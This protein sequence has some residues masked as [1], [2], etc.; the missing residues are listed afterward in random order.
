MHSG[1]GGG[2]GTEHA[3]TAESGERD[4]AAAR[5]DGVRGAGDTRGTGL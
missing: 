5:E 2:D 4:G 1:V 3:G